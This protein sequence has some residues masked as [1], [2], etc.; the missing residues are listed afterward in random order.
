MPSV[1]KETIVQDKHNPHTIWQA[2]AAP[3]ERNPRSSELLNQRPKDEARQKGKSH[4]QKPCR[5]QN[6]PM[7]K[8]TWM[9]WRKEVTYLMDYHPATRTL[10]PAKKIKA[11]RIQSLQTCQDASPSDQLFTESMDTEDYDIPLEWTTL[12]PCTPPDDPPT[13]LIGKT[14][15]AQQLAITAAKD[16]PEKTLEEMVPPHYHE[17]RDVFEKQASE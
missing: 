17:Y 4:R 13:I 11:M 10:K 15:F 14:N 8:R 5:P 2:K 7:D 9:M 6:T 1:P 16:K 3:E 12:D